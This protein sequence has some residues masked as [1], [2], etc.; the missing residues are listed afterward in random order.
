MRNEKG[1]GKHR[2]IKDSK[3][4]LWTITQ[5]NLQEMDKFL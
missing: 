5:N 3:R 4:L 2:N 1:D